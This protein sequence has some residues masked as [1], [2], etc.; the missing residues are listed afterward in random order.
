VIK[1]VHPLADFQ[2]CIY[3]KDL[4]VII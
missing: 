4:S 3:T 2:S 1:E